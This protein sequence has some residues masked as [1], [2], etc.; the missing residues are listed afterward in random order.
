MTVL[1]TNLLLQANTGLTSGVQGVYTGEGLPPVPAK[2]AAK[3]RCGTYVDMGELLPEFWATMREEDQSKLEAKAQ[4]ARFIRDIFTWLQC[5]GMYVSVLALQH[6]SWIP[7]LMAR[8]PSFRPAWTMQ[9]WNGCNMILHFGA[10]R[11]S[12]GSLSG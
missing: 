3:I 5:C 9:A 12:P 2:L 4:R 10:R 11:H 8:L 7:E 6:P 1:M